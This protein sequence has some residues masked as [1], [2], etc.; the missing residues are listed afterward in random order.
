MSI[1][2]NDHEYRLYTDDTEFPFISHQM[3][4]TTGNFLQFCRDCRSEGYKR[5]ELVAIVGNVSVF[6][7][8]G[9][10]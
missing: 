4:D 3:P 9:D 5:V 1:R 6:I 2:F 8:V 10:N 7:P